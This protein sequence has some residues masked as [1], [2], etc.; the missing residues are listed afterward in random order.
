MQKCAVAKIFNNNQER[1]SN[2]KKQLLG[3][4]LVL[5]IGLSSVCFAADEVKFAVVDGNEVFT[6]FQ[7]AIEEDLKKEFKDQQQKLVA[8]QA[9]LQKMGE[10]LDKDAATMS[11][12]EV[13]KMQALFAEKQMEFQKL[14]IEYNEAYN[15]AGNKAFQALI[16]KVQAASTAMAT[17]KGYSIVL[18]R[19]AVLYA[20][21]KFDV[22]KD[23]IAR[24]Q[25]AEKPKQ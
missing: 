17:E 1:A 12:S 25:A 15:E 21:P 4:L 6:Q 3:G 16:E 7:P 2:M 5:G 24:I 9:D 8:M 10:K 19:G 13:E 23:L 18:Q 11:V 22:T 14:S 20:D